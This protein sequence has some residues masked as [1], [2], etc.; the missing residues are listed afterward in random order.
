MHCVGFLSTVILVVTFRVLGIA[1]CRLFY[2]T[3]ESRVI[4]QT[5]LCATRGQDTSISLATE[6]SIIIIAYRDL[7]RLN[8]IK[9]HLFRTNTFYFVMCRKCTIPEYSSG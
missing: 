8:E 9:L 3:S 2:V 5:L 4:T 1:D 6:D 7:V